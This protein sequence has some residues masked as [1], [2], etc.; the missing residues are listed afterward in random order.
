MK[1]CQ[2]LL[3]L[4]SHRVMPPAVPSAS[5]GVCFPARSDKSLHLF[6]HTGLLF[7]D[8]FWIYVFAHNRVSSCHFLQGISSLLVGGKHPSSFPRSQNCSSS[9]APQLQLLIPWLRPHSRGLQKV[10]NSLHFGDLSFYLLFSEL[11]TPS[12]CVSP[13]ARV[14]FNQR[15]PLACIYAM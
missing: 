1:I 5:L 13:F 8:I 4:A 14:I 11:A 3:G 2:G 15:G 9:G 6:P 10:P 7:F 12:V